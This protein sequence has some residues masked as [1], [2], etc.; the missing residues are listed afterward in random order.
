MIFIN[1]NHCCFV[2]G[3]DELKTG[4]HP[5]GSFGSVNQTHKGP[6]IIILNQYAEGKEQKNTI[7]FSFFAHYSSSTAPLAAVCVYVKVFLIAVCIGMNILLMIPN[8]GTE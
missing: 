7:L 2:D 6:V 8:P 1:P 5:I 3:I 4:K